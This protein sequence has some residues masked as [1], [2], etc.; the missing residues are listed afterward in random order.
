MV[1]LMMQ[2]E[3]VMCQR[4]CIEQLNRNLQQATKYTILFGN[5]VLLFYGDLRRI[6]PVVPS[7]SR[8]QIINACMKSSLL[9]HSFRTVKITE[10]M[11]LQS[12]LDKSAAR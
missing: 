9:Y 11:G 3:I 5:K 12:L 8:A 6:L 1:S 4:L 10:N 2:I 7:R